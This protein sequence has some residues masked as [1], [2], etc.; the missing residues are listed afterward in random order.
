MAGKYAR[1]FVEFSICRYAR[2]C[3]EA[4]NFPRALLSENCLPLRTDDVRGQISE[5][6]FARN[7]GYCL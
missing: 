1:I 3:L 7:G 5:D 2:I 4:H 6:I